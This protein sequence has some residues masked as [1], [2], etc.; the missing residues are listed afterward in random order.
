MCAH[1]SP[2]YCACTKHCCALVEILVKSNRPLCKDSQINVESTFVHEV[3][4]NGK[5]SAIWPDMIK[6]KCVVVETVD[7][8]FIAPLPNPFER[9]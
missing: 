2:G 3:R 1:Q 8:L 5:I 4:K 6:M 7:N 9:D